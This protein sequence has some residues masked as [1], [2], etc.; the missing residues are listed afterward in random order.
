MAT[1]KTVNPTVLD[2]AL[3]YVRDKV[4]HI[5]VASAND[6]T[7]FAFLATSR[8]AS[9]V[10]TTGAGLFTL[11][12]GSGSNGRKLTVPAVNDIEIIA[13]GTAN[14][15]AL[16]NSAGPNEVLYVTTCTAKPLTIADRV[17]IPTWDITL[18]DPS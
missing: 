18:T 9:S 3:T 11:S 13:T 14:V 17:N 1:G 7:N 12:A 16:Y 6:T 8:L 10:I 15:V 2:Q 5:L 4:T